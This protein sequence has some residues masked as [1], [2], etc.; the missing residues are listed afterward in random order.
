MLQLIGFDSHLCSRFWQTIASHISSPIHRQMNEMRNL[1]PQDQNLQIFNSI[2]CVL[3]MGSNCYALVNLARSPFKTRRNSTWIVVSQPA[4][5]AMQPALIVAIWSIQD[6]EGIDYTQWADVMLSVTQTIIPVVNLFHTIMLDL[7]VLRMFSVFYP[8]IQS[9]LPLLRTGH[10]L[11]CYDGT[12]NYRSNVIT[13][14]PVMGLNTYTLVISMLFTSSVFVYDN[15]QMVYV[16]FLVSMFSFSKKQLKSVNE[17]NHEV[18]EDVG[19]IKLI[20]LQ[21]IVVLI[22]LTSL[23]DWFS[24]S[25]TAYYGFDDILSAF[26]VSLRNELIAASDHCISY[27]C[28]ERIPYHVLPLSCTNSKLW[29]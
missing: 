24:I 8:R 25:L 28:S 18:T 1:T 26:I 13:K 16:C 3:S 12:S 27:M 6:M 10:R 23:I 9:V 4:N 7:D 20:L 15:A 5:L 17:W 29:Y 14:I 11:F 22:T 19:K 21:R 2:L